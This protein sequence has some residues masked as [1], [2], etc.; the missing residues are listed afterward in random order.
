MGLHI[1]RFETTNGELEEFEVK[2]EVLYPILSNSAVVSKESFIGEEA[3]PKS[4]RALVVDVQAP[5][6][7]WHLSGT[8]FWS[9]TPYVERD[10]FYQKPPERKEWVKT[11]DTK[12]RKNTAVNQPR[13]SKASYQKRNGLRQK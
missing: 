13:Q 10:R 3:K 5:I 11:P 9:S 12:R 2:I 8:S 4:K 7:V 6:S 1:S